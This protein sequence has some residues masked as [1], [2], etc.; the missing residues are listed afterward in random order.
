MAR[1]RAWVGVVAV[2]V[3]GAVFLAIAVGGGGD[4]DGG[5][6]GLTGAD[7]HSLVVDPADPQRVYVGGH[8]AVSVSTDGGA[9]WT[10]VD[11]LR[12]A[13]A[14]GWAFTNDAAYVS[15]HPGLNE[16][17][18]AGRSFERINQGL[19]STDVHALGGTDGVLYGASPAVGVFASR[20]GPGDWEVLTT[21]AGQ[22]FFGRI[23]VDPADDRHLI[24]TDA[25]VGVA[26]SR[27]GGDTWQVV[28]SGLPAATW[29]S[30]GGDGL[31]L[32]V[33]SGPAGAAASRD[34]GQTWEPVD[35]PDGA[36]LVEAVPG[37]PDLLYAGTHD[38]SR[39]QVQASRD[40]GRSWS[41]P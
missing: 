11:S 39:V 33:A 2:A 17:T 41:G 9:T 12:G 6:G 16:S 37:E 5:A 10:E 1:N 36:T 7:F 34:G 8:Q 3:V 30:R 21:A 22:G 32:L 23:V 13:D 25:Q 15:G 27:D 14:M 35:T 40:G 19:P 28:D 20:G 31:E 26:E 38:G 4:D 18:D 24:A 29:M